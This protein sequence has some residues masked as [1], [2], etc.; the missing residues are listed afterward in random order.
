MKSIDIPYIQ[1]L[2]NRCKDDLEQKNYDSVITKS[3]TIIEEVLVHILESNNEQIPSDGNIGNLYN[4]VKVLYHMKQ[5]KGYDNRVNSLLCGL[6]RIVEAI[7]SMRNINSDAHGV[8]SKRIE[9]KEREARLV[10][11][12]AMVFCEYLLSI[13]NTKGGKN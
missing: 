5:G 10:M 3:R 13:R 9:I 4:Q 12:S 6:E 7:G 2:A 1:D 8:G 11:N